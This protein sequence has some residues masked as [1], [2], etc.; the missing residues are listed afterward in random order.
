MLPEAATNPGKPKKN[1]IPGW[2]NFGAGIKGAL[3]DALLWPL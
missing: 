3:S 2:R 1:R